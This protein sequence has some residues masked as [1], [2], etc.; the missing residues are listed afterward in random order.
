MLIC[1][2]SEY[3]RSYRER[4]YLNRIN[5]LS[6]ILNFVKCYNVFLSLRFSNDSIWNFK[7]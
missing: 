5:I 1:F 2:V 3:Y 4:V 7:V 6:L